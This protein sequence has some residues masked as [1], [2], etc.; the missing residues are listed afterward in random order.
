MHFIIEDLLA[1]WNPVKSLI[2]IRSSKID[3]AL[4]MVSHHFRKMIL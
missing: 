1:G 4:N 2:V 3:R